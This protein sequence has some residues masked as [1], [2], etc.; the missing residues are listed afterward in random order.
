MC[1][2]KN[3]VLW[4]DPCVPAS[5]EWQGRESGGLWDSGS[6]RNVTKHFTC[7]TTNCSVTK[8]FHFERGTILWYFHHLCSATKTCFL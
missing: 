3:L 5:L 1:R 4:R 2:Y 8:K 7:G 6:P